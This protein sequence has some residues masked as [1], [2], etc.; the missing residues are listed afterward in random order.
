MNTSQHLPWPMACFFLITIIGLG[1]S[2][3]LAPL[4]AEAEGKGDKLLA[5]RYLK[6]GLLVA[7]LIGIPMMVANHYSAH[8]LAYMKQPERD[9]ELAFSYLRILGIGILPFLVFFMGKSFV[10]GLSLTIPAMY[11]TL[12]GLVFNV[13]ANWLLIFGNLGFP[14]LELDGA[15]YGTVMS[16]SFMALLMLG[17]IWH[18][19]RSY[20]KGWKGPD[21]AIIGRILRLGI[22]SGLQYFFEVGAFVGAA[23]MIGWLG[24]AERAAHQI[25]LRMAA[26]SFM[27]VLGISAGATIRVGDALGRN[28]MLQ[29]R[30]AG[31]AGIHLA[32]VFMVISALF[33]VWYRNWLPKLFLSTSQEMM[34]SAA[35]ADAPDNAE[36]LAMAAGLMIFAGLFQ[37]FDGIQAVGVG[38][39]RGIQDVRIPTLITFVV[40]WILCLPLAYLL[41]FTAGWGL[42]GMWTSFVVSLAVAAICLSWRF[43]HMTQIKT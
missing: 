14:R 36:V 20:L 10:D 41:S 6:Q 17:Y 23:F 35:Y 21:Q 42:Y 1:T 15:G 16:R 26:V 33:F 12:L 24:S 8:L 19:K 39:L 2:M 34:A 7:A 4:T 32:I 9:V 3:I 5:G 31:L 43:M 29:V 30:R 11:I 13:L 40:Y 18:R 27:V 28:N 25:A 38:I 37:I 22:P